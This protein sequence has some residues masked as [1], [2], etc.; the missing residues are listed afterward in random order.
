MWADLLQ[1][2]DYL[3]FFAFWATILIGS[4]KWLISH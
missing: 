3:A 4:V 1:L 2:I